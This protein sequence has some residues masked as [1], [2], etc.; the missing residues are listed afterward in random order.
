[1][2]KSQT[3]PCVAIRHH[4][5]SIPRHPD[6]GPICHLIGTALPDPGPA[7]LLIKSRYQL[8]CHYGLG[9]VILQLGMSRASPDSDMAAAVTVV[10]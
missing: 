7:L 8:V 6:G 10:C 1:M 2:E 3:H 5:T 4:L 9:L